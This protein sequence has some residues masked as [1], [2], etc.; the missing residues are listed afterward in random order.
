MTKD[1]VFSTE[2]GLYCPL[3]DIHID[4]WRAV[5]RA[6]ITHAHADHARPGCRTYLC[7][8]ECAPILRTRLGR[9]INIQTLPY[10]S[11]LTCNEVRITLYP[12][13]HVLGSAQVLLEPLAD[14]ARNHPSWCISGDYK[15]A[16]DPT[17]TLFEP[18]RCGVFITEST[19]GLPIYRWPETSLV[20][21]DINS[22][23][24][25]NQARSFNSIIYTYA[26]GKAQR[27]LAGLDPSIGPI[28]V[29]GAV[30]RLLPPYREAGIALPTTERATIDSA[31]RAD[32]RAIIIAPPSAAGT[33]WLKKFGKHSDAFAS[34]WMQIRG[35]RRR[36]SIDRGFVL[37][38]HAD[39]PG[40]LSAIEATGAYRVG[41]THGAVTPLVRFL[42]E[43]RSLDAFPISTRYEGEVEEQDDTSLED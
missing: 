15:L 9:N 11:P 32:G 8:P 26:F 42:K 14:H 25:E 38:D 18:V 36:R 20:F 34:G 28:L 1:L 13:G 12:A 23:W 3:A 27:L 4:P 29:H 21:D 17:C 31:K 40:L 33:M 41:V 43:E 30:D 35:T 37:S 16:F 19:F 24:R 7:T 39:W 2:N 6:V 10:D 5:D 22:W